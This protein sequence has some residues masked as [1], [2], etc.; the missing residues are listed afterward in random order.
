MREKPIVTL[1]GENG[2]A[3]NIIR[4]VKSA[5]RK[6]GYDQAYLDGYMEKAISGDYDNLLRVTT[7]YVEVE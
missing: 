4:R 5:L 6:A 1:V 2:N 7:E 3:F